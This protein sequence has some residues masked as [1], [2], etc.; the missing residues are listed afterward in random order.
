MSLHSKRPC[1]KLAA[2]AASNC[3]F[4]QHACCLHYA[5]AFTLQLLLACEAIADLLQHEGLAA[6]GFAT[7]DQHVRRAYEKLMHHRKKEARL[8]VLLALIMRW[9]VY[10]RRKV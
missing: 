1:N 6:A 9:M 2:L 10:M 7:S 8:L 3:L 5:P 4:S